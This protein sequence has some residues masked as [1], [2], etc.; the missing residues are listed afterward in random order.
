MKFSK[1]DTLVLSI[2]GVLVIFQAWLYVGDYTVLN[3]QGTSMNPVLED[4]DIVF[5]KGNYK[6]IATGDIVSYRYPADI[7]GTDGAVIHRINWSNGTHYRMKGDNN[8]YI[9]GIRRTIK[10]PNGKVVEKQDIPFNITSEQID[11]KAKHLLNISEIG[12]QAN[13]TGNDTERYSLWNT[14]KKLED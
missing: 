12:V 2:I 5:C 4:G 1:S 10:N 11:C 7:K 3:T 8:D 9:D 6:D 13:S 14:Y